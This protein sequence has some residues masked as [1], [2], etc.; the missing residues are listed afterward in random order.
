MCCLQPSSYLI[1]VLESAAVELVG[2]EN[3]KVMAAK[4]QQISKP[5]RMHNR[6]RRIRLKSTSHGQR[7]ILED[8][9]N[10]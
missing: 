4:C 9:T 8:L 1:S 10:G 6:A 3:G 5:N 2:G 7:L